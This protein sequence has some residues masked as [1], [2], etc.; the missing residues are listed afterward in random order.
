MA[1][2]VIPK[3]P[4]AAK[5]GVGVGIAALLLA[6]YFVV[7][8]GDVASQLEAAAG[9]EQRLKKELQDWKKSQFSYNKDLAELTER[10]Q[11]KT[12]LNKVLPA[13]TEYPAF[14]SAIQSVANTT[15]V[16]L[17]AWN[18]EDEVKKEFYARIPMK[19]ELQG[20]YHQIARFFFGVGQL[21]RI[22]NMENISLSQPVARGDEVVVGVKVLATAFRSL[23]NEAAA[24][25]DK[26][27]KALGEK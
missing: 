13:T 17:I 22:I 5:A 3:L 20:R 16:S 1:D 4:L 9:S 25:L 21:D 15:G 7:F 2:L 24:G 27:G 10:E 6:A 12:E 23:G 18:P 14:L 11:R 19:L 26:R 8:Y